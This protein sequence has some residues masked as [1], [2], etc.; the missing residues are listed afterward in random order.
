MKKANFL[1]E[2]KNHA[3]ARVLSEITQYM[4]GKKK[5]KMTYLDLERTCNVIPYEDNF[6]MRRCERENFL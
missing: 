6:K 1:D 2:K 4:T 5:A 3:Y